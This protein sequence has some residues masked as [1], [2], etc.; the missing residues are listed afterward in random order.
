[1]ILTWQRS[2]P[3]LRLSPAEHLRVMQGKFPSRWLEKTANLHSVVLHLS[4]RKVS[5]LSPCIPA[6]S[7]CQGQGAL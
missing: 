2:S 4:M 7:Q 5:S 6:L 3:P 1:M